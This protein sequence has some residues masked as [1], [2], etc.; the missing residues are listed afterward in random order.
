MGYFKE[1]CDCCQKVVDSVENLKTPVMPDVYIPIL[2]AYQKA[3]Y[4]IDSNR[5]KEIS[6]LILRV[7]DRDPEMKA[8]YNK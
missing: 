4:Y 7:C 6:D 3:I 5:T 2:V 1:C 8:E